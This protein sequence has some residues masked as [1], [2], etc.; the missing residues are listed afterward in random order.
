MPVNVSII[1]S[2][3]KMALWLTYALVDGLSRNQQSTWH[4]RLQWHLANHGLVT[5]S[6]GPQCVAWPSRRPLSS[7]D[8]Q[9][10]SRWLIAQPELAFAAI[11]IRPL[12]DLA[13]RQISRI[14]RS[15][16]ASNDPHF[17]LDTRVR[18]S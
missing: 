17:N 8:R 4:R 12:A 16:E 15:I 2:N 7:S 1:N 6:R 5:I 3:A 13:S 18:E 14:A 11:E 9:L 10:L